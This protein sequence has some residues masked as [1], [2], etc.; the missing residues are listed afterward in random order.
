MRH[1]SPAVAEF[2]LE[3]AKARIALLE[4]KLAET[5]KILEVARGLIKAYQ[6]GSKP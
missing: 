6:G 2:S 1:V 5:D 3:Q 4:E